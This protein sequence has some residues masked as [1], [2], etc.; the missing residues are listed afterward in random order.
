MAWK[1]QHHAYYNGLARSLMPRSVLLL[2]IGAT[3]F[4]NYR[5][6][7]RYCRCCWQELISVLKGGSQ[8]NA[9]L[10]TS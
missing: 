3:D 8:P 7:V 4:V 9:L 6:L 5:H 2:P 10:A 1:A